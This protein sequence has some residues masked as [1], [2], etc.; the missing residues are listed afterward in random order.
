MG[1]GD[2]V[3]EADVEEVGLEDGVCLGSVEVD[4]VCLERVDVAWVCL[5][6]EDVDVTM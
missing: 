6:S 3:G 4:G 2:N 5:G 1:V